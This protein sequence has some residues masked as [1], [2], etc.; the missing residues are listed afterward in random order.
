MTDSLGPPAGVGPTAVLLA[1][2]RQLLYFDDVHGRRHDERDLRELPDRALT[3]ELRYDVVLDEWVVIAAHRQDRIFLPPTTECPL[4]P[5]RSGVDTEIPGSDYDVVVFENRFPAL[6]PAAEA[7]GNH[8]RGNGRCEVVCFTSD[9]DSSFAELPRERLLTV[10]RTWVDRT[11]ALSGVDGIE[12]VF[13]FENR[14]AEIGVTLQ[15]P[16]GQIYSYPFIPPRAQRAMESARRHHHRYGGCLFCQQVNDELTEGVRVVAQSEH[17]VAFVPGAARWPY[18]V[19]LYPRRHVPDLPALTETEM[20]DLMDLY[21]GLLRRFD[22][23]FPTPAPY[24]AGW[25]QAPVQQDRDLAHLSL[26]LFTLRR[27][28]EKLKHLAGSESGQGVWVNDVLPEQS[29]ET[30]RSLQI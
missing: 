15:H 6:S 14:G 20:A 1:D 25:H 3:S 21:V 4:C 30:L 2:G 23:L 16:H 28:P 11:K 26:Q 13:I 10:A 7:V 29:A 12:Y 22:R 8:P 18:E 9:H 24:I 27:A 17:A 5:S 19:H